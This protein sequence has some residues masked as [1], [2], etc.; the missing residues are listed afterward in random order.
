[1]VSV[2]RNLAGS[3]KLLKISLLLARLGI[4]VALVRGCDKPIT[5]GA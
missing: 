5:A 3:G 4:A 1:M 2:T